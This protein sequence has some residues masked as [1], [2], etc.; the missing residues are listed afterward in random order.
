MKEDLLSGNFGG[1]ATKT[2]RKI[3]MLRGRRMLA[4]YSRNYFDVFERYWGS[5]GSMGVTCGYVREPGSLTLPFGVG[6]LRFSTSSKNANTPPE[7]A[8]TLLGAFF[9]LRKQS[10]PQVTPV[11]GSMGFTHKE[12]EGTGFPRNPIGVGFVFFRLRRKNHKP[13]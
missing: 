2:T 9:A 11:E 5:M 4:A 3:R 8:G 1:V 12:H 7:W 13:H 10:P 6:C